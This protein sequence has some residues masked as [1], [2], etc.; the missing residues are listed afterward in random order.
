MSD[1]PALCGIGGTFKIGDTT[2]TWSPLTIGDLALL[3][4]DVRKELGSRLDCIGAAKAA[5]DAGGL[6]D[7][8]RKAVM[9]TAAREYL[10]I[11]RLGAMQLL[12]ELPASDANALMLLAHLRKSH[13]DLTLDQVRA[14]AAHQAAVLQ[15]R[16]SLD[17]AWK[18]CD[19]RP[20]GLSSNRGPDSR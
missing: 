3:E 15:F 18:R 13:P 5:C 2:Y 8:D 4:T 7:N 1:L 10:R 12:G 6:K 20:R 16:R 9:E 17:H 14:M 19:R 11:V